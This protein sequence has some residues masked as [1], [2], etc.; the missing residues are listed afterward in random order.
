MLI[1]Y[2]WAKEIAIWKEAILQLKKHQK[3]QHVTT[4]HYKWT[5][6]KTGKYLPMVN[7]CY[8]HT[9]HNLAAQI[10]AVCSQHNIPATW[11]LS[12][13]FAP[14]MAGSY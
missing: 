13:K 14:G 1:E 11:K 2:D 12:G 6:I 5:V 4:M 10:G 9:N 8:L 7:F 3:L